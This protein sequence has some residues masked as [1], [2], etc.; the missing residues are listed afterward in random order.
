MLFM[1]TRIISGRF[2]CL[3]FSFPIASLMTWQVFSIL[4][5]YFSVSLEKYRFFDCHLVHSKCFLESWYSFFCFF[6]FLFFNFEYK[7]CF[8]LDFFYS[9]S[10]SRALSIFSFYYFIHRKK[11][12]LYKMLIWNYNH[13]Y[14]CCC[15][16]YY[17]Y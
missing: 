7:P 3:Y 14:Y 12:K 11:S 9:V 15:Y 16:Y 2:C 17:Y 8:L 13:Y 5:L 1:S 10:C 4:L 6:H